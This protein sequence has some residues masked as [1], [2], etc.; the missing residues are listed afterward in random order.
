MSDGE[1]G[2]AGAWRPELRGLALA[3]V[4]LD[5]GFSELTKHVAAGLGSSPDDFDLQLAVALA[6]L[7]RPVDRPVSSRAERW[8]EAEIGPLR[9]LATAY[10]FQRQ[11]PLGFTMAFGSRDAGERFG[12]PIR[13]AVPIYP[14]CI[15]M[16][17]VIARQAARRCLAGV[18]SWNVPHYGCISQQLEGKVPQELAQLVAVGLAN[19]RCMNLHGRGSCARADHAYHTFTKLWFGS[20]GKAGSMRA[21]QFVH[22]LVRGST[23]SKV[24]PGAVRTGSIYAMLPAR[25]LLI[26]NTEI[27]SDEGCDHARAEGPSHRLFRKLA[28]V[29]P[30]HP[31]GNPS[32]PVMTSVRR[33]HSPCRH[34]VAGPSDDDRPTGRSCPL[35]SC[36]VAGPRARW[37]TL[38]ARN[39]ARMK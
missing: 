39:P 32:F 3:R 36:C 26:G 14:V 29:S 12:S 15:P 28:V 8:F 33:W 27:P 22:H 24:R 18:A 21:D 7:L 30:D 25:W 9:Q 6:A 23:E 31:C 2:A 16:L 10:P 1:F 17:E 37:T 4:L 5:G 35:C 34:L 19:G 13:S 20:E 11:D 38:W